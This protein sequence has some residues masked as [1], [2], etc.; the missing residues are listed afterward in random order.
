MERAAAR[1]HAAI[2]GVLGDRDA[3]P[4]GARRR[5]GAA[6]V[7]GVLSSRCAGFLMER[8]AARALPP[9]RAFWATGGALPADGAPPRGCMPPS[10]ASWAAGDALPDGT[11]RRAGSWRA[12]P[13][14]PPACG[15]AAAG[16]AA[17]RACASFADSRR[18][19]VRRAFA[20]AAVNLGGTVC[21]SEAFPHSS[22]MV[23]SN[24]RV[25]GPEPFSVRARRLD[26][27]TRRFPYVSRETYALPRRRTV[28]EK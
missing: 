17:A 8:A 14:K 12:S 2:A 24:M 27:Q 13:W 6:A 4:A 25:A 1:V 21:I 26:G 9:S 18:A 3:L 16:D 15:T 7:A 23:F 5:A 20:R 19:S 28:K 22:A 10:R 11:R